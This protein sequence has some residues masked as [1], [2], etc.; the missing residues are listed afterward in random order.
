MT[1]IVSY[2]ILAGGYNLR[3]NGA[4]RTHELVNIIRSAHPDIV[5]IAEATNAQVAE[6]P[7]VIEEIAQQL[8]MQLILGGD[9]HDYEY[10]VACMTRLPVVASRIHRIKGA[11]HFSRTVLEVCVEEANGEHLT[12]FVTHLSAA[13]SHGWAGTHI[14]EREVR[15]LLRITRP[16]R[17]QGLPHVIVGDFNSLAP[18]D[19]FKASFLLRYVVHMDQRNRN[20]AYISDGNPHLNFVVPPRLRFLNPLLRIIP[21]HKLLSALFDIAASLYAPRGP[22]VMLQNAGYNDCYRQSNHHSWGFTCPA[23]APAGRIDFIFANTPLAQRLESCH[24]ILLGEHG[25]KG[26][27][28]SDHLAVAATFAVAIP[29]SPRSETPYEVTAIGS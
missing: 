25:V 13:F 14:R 26:D 16:H 28:A 12:M 2:N 3:E 27:Q 8:G 7:M 5:G 29:T 21:Q 6:K 1:N 4:K 19:S 23:A 11:G 17:E 20:K 22:I 15:D 10:Q 18:G 9:P 24:E